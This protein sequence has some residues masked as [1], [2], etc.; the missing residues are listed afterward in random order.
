MKASQIPPC[1]TKSQQLFK[2][3][4]KRQEPQARWRFLLPAVRAYLPASSF[5]HSGW[6]KGIGALAIFAPLPV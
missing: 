1:A 5:L 6:P 3:T 4:K 2:S